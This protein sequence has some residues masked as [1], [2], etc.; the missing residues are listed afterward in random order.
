MEIRRWWTPRPWYWVGGVDDPTLNTQRPS[1]DTAKEC[2]EWCVDWHCVS[3]LLVYT[4]LFCGS[5]SWA[6]KK[7]PGTKK[8]DRTMST[9][10][11]TTNPRQHLP[12]TWGDR[13][14]VQLA[15]E[16]HGVGTGAIG[17]V[18]GEREW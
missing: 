1:K 6:K 14:A 15:A 8:K 5:T 12:Q 11:E 18:L 9:F 3:V 16:V 10:G 2:G 13:A 17:S 4:I 7:V